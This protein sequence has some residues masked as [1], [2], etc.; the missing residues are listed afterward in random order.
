MNIF[1]CLIVIGICVSIFHR[2]CLSLLVDILCL[3]EVFFFPL[4]C[5]L[6][7]RSKIII[8]EHKK[9]WVS[10]LD[11][12]WWNKNDWQKKSP[13]NDKDHYFYLY[14]KCVTKYKNVLCLFFMK[15]LP[16]KKRFHV[17]YLFTRDFIL[18]TN[19]NFDFDMNLMIKRENIKYLNPCNLFEVI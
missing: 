4:R 6:S 14:R 11:A 3:I 19:W 10:V 2:R 1:Q 8:D 12:C 15:I 7:K 13:C 18:A 16:N 5:R 9:I 17:F